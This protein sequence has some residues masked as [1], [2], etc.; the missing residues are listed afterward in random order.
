MQ[1]PEKTGLWSV[2]PNL[3]R[4]KS[5]NGINMVFVPGQNVVLELNEVA[6]D[7]M[8]A[9]S[10]GPISFDALSSVLMDQYQV[11]DPGAFN[12]EVDQ[13]LERFTKHGLIVPFD[14]GGD[15]E[16]AHTVR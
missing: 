8:E 1:S 10:G 4:R 3:K 12:E 16:T 9:F 5:S 7:I 13:V 6:G 14:K 15:S 11:E 2:P